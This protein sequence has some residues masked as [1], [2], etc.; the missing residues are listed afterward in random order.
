MDR[1]RRLTAESAIED[2]ILA[3]RDSRRR[4]MF[5][6]LA[7]ALP[8]HTWH[9]LFS[10]LGRLSRTGAVA[11]SPH[12]WDYEVVFLEA[13]RSSGHSRSCTHESRVGRPR[14]GL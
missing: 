2:D 6:D 12:R 13:P 5:L 3:A 4:V 11:L 14:S 8:Q 7:D 9:K 1:D 10:A